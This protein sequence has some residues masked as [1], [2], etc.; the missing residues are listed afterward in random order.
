M[1]C[2]DFYPHPTALPIKLIQTHISYVLLTGSYVYKVKKAIK[3]DFLDFSTLPLRKHFCEEEL[4]L[5][6]RGAPGIYLEVVPVTADGDDLRL[7]GS[8]AA[9]EY[10]LKMKQFPQEDLF[11]SQL[12]SGKL[13][14]A[15]IVQAAQTLAAYHKQAGTDARLAQFGQPQH[16]RKMIEDNYSVAQKFIG[17]PQSRHQFELTKEFTDRWIREFS[18]LFADRV[19]QGRVREC[20]GDLHLGNICRWEERIVFFDC[21][22]FSEPLRWIDVMNDAAFTAMDLD[23]GDRPDLST[24]FLN[25]Y[26]EHTGDWEGLQVIP[27]YLCARAYVRAMVHSLQLDNAELSL[28]ELEGARES[29]MRYYHLAWQYTVRRK[30]QLILV[31]G[32]SGTGKS[33][34]ARRLA[35]QIKAVHIRSDAVRKHLV[36]IEVESHGGPQL[37]TSEMTHRTYDRLL[38]L[39][40]L[41]AGQGFSV[42]LDAK[43]DRA[44][45]RQQAISRSR[46]SNISIRII[47]CTAPDE[48]IHSRLLHRTG[49]ISDAS[50]DLLL[51]QR[52]AFEPF[53]EEERD[54]LTVID[55]ST[56]PDAAALA[57]L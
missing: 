25:T 8:G 6:Q 9:V 56:P 12:A 57:G 20:H 35:Q 43:F 31:S 21:I 40:L 19:Q 45:F 44:L 15:E 46:S 38:H 41:L 3:L 7:G 28:G 49:D 24:L 47:Q 48:V 52:A 36:G 26:A 13:T 14:D 23:A 54:I 18:Q 33:T 53:D 29:A 16:I 11:S 10:A 17:G 32:L 5:N 2:H 55:T 37:Y 27:L 4:R 22:E 30:G 39:G 50:A 1:L 42:I 34:L 51:Q